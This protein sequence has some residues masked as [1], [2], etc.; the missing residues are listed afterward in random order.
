MSSEEI[1]VEVP[2]A[3]MVCLTVLTLT[4]PASVLLLQARDCSQIKRLPS[5]LS[6]TRYSYCQYCMV[7]V[8]HTQGVV[9]EGSFIAQWPCNTVA[10]SWAMQVGE[11]NTRMIEMRA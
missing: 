11:G 2:F 8:W 7:Y 9:V 10:L 6:F 3:R 1:L 5:N 4:P